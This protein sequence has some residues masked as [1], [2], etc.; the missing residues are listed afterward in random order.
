MVRNL[1][2]IRQ[3]KAASFQTTKLDVAQK[4]IVQKHGLTQYFPQRFAITKLNVLPTLFQ[5]CIIK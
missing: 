3:L 2:S 5:A 4:C 1:T